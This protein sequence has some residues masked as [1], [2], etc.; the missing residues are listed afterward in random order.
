MTYG[1]TED[2]NLEQKVKC[3]KIAKLKLYGLL[4]YLKLSNVFYVCCFHLCITYITL[5]HI[6]SK[7]KIKP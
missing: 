4:F 6:L 5:Q 2:A 1:N 3:Q 7:K